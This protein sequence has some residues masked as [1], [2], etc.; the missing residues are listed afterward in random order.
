MLT[1]NAKLRASIIETNGDADNILKIEHNGDTYKVSDVKWVF[2]YV[3][4]TGRVSKEGLLRPAT[5][6][7]FKKIIDENI[8]CKVQINSNNEIILHYINE[9]E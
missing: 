5:H 3:G 7:D 2:D 6:N 9:P 1:D 4:P 8:E